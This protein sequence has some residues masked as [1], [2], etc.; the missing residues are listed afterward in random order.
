M[1]GM[2]EAAKKNTKANLD[3]LLRTFSFVPDDRQTWSPS[4]TAKSAVQIVA[5]CAVSN[6]AFAKIIAGFQFSPASPQE[7]FAAMEVEEKKLNTAEAAR[8]ALIKSV[9]PVYEALDKLTPEQIGAKVRTPFMTARMPFFMNV[10]ALHMGNHASQ[11]DYL[12][13]CWGD[14]DPHFG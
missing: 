14:T 11:I 6:G 13:T 9:E 12:Q 4:P 10:P 8:E 7:I 3:R 5:H 2:I 1:E